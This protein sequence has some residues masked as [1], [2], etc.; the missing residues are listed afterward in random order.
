MTRF[1]ERW[2]VI[3]RPYSFASQRIL[4]NVTV[5]D[6]RHAHS[7][8]Y[9]EPELARWSSV[10]VPVLAYSLA[11][12]RGSH[13]APLVRCLPVVS[14]QQGPA[15]P[16]GAVPCLA[17]VRDSHRG[18]LAQD[19][20]V[21]SARLEP[22]ALRGAVPCLAVVRDSHHVLVVQCPLVV[23][24]RQGPALAQSGAA[25]RDSHRV[26]VVR[27]PLVASPSQGPALA[28]SGAAVRDFLRGLPVHYS[29][30]G[31]RAQWSRPE[32]VGPGVPA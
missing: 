15:A 26:L 28:R 27:H 5:R 2:A 31:P 20:P 6:F 29:P 18:L 12:V 13:L 30:D 3:D 23:S 19:P 1:G 11:S 24:V 17:V 8:R 32:P 7:E 4:S 16:R 22:A 21:V 9:S 25:V 14:A 10:P